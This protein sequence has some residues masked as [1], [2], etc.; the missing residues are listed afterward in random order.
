MSQIAAAHVTEALPQTGWK[1]FLS[2]ATG[3]WQ[4]GAS[5]GKKA[6]RRKFILRSLAMPLH[7]VSLMNNLASQPHL[8]SM[9]NAQPGLPCRLH[10]PYL[11][12]PLKRKHTRDTI[13]YHYQKIAEKMPKKMLNGHFSAEGYRLATLV[14]KNNELMFIDLTSHDIEGK[15][16]EAFLNFC[17]EEGV[18][19]ARMTFTLN[20]FEGKNTFFIGCLQGAKTWVP[21]EAIQAATKACHGLFPKRMLLE[22]ACELA[23]L[24]DAERILAVGNGTH[25]YRSWRYEKKKKDSLHADYDSFWQS[26]SGEP[27][28]DGLFALPSSVERK[29]LEDIASKKRAEY[30][31]RY[32]LLDGMMNSINGHF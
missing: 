16:G 26:M 25:I 32:E 12:L 29:P 30:R 24:L 17:N 1:L 31:R 5:W 27:R 11:A 19:L 6:Y 20:Q 14:G 18:P 10:R 2:L 22:V 15:E 3:E 9:L 4:P 13:A 8:A 7:T 23:K 21:H 28:A